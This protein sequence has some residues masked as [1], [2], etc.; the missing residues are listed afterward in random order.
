MKF[1]ALIIGAG[2]LAATPVQAGTLQTWACYTEGSDYTI[3]AVADSSLSSSAKIKF[4]ST[5]SSSSY[6]VNGYTIRG[7]I[8]PSTDCAAQ[9]ITIVD[10][11]TTYSESN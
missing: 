11:G 1:K 9:T 4:G 3:F 7:T 2:L 8:S 5:D 6:N 10:G